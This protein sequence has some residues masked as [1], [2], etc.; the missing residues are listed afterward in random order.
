MQ[1][2]RAMPPAERM[3]KHRRGVVAKLDVIEAKLEDLRVEVREVIAATL[4]RKA[5]SSSEHKH[6][7]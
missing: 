1:Q 3:A 5:V 7:D 2:T 4:T 6:A